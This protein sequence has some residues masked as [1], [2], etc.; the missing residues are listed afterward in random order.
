MCCL[1]QILLFIIMYVHEEKKVQ[2]NGVKLRSN[3][4]FFKRSVLL[5]AFC[6]GRCQGCGLPFAN[7]T[8]ALTAF[9]LIFRQ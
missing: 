9:I 1:V 2:W 8:P 3:L 6:Y 5:L 7:E 4:L